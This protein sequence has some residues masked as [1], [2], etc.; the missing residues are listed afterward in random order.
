MCI[1]QEPTLYSKFKDINIYNMHNSELQQNSLKKLAKELTSVLLTNTSNNLNRRISLNKFS[2]WKAAIIDDNDFF[3]TSNKTELL[4][5]IN[6]NLS[7][8]GL[9]LITVKNGYY[10]QKLNEVDIPVGRDFFDNLKEEEKRILANKTL[11]YENTKKMT[12]FKIENNIPDNKLEE[13]GLIFLICAILFIHGG[14][15]L[16]SKLEEALEL[17]INLNETPCGT[18]NLKLSAFLSFL[19]TSGY[20]KM[21]NGNKDLDIIEHNSTEIFKCVRIGPTAL[22]EFTAITMAKFVSEIKRIPFGDVINES[23]SLHSTLKQEAWYPD[24]FQL[25]STAKSNANEEMNVIAN[26]QSSTQ[27]VL[28]QRRNR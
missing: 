4:K 25:Q 18:K 20:I 21:Y 22:E 6:E 28:S 9:K 24:D 10:L 8:V 12:D 15:M 14:R 2:D 13:D 27:A 17:F 23:T 1:N 3:I 16:V 5:E 26:K 11:T 19:G 7:I